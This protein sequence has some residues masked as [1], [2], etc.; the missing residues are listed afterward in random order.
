MFVHR[1]EA[2]VV[3]NCVVNKCS[4]KEVPNS[5]FQAVKDKKHYTYPETL[6]TYFDVV[7]LGKGML[8]IA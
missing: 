4:K 3:I 6:R 2:R 5:T 7:F 1:E 8:T